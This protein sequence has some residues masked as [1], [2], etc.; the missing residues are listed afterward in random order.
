[1]SLMGR[2][3]VPIGNSLDLGKSSKLYVLVLKN[4][5]GEAITDPQVRCCLMQTQ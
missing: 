2:P 1:M 4:S 5:E 3:Q